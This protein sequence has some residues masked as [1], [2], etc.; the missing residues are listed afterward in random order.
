MVYE[1]KCAQC[2]RV[3][4][5]GGEKPGEG[6]FDRRDPLPENAMEFNG[7]IYCKECVKEFVEFGTG[8]IIER[9]ER[10]E[11][12]VNEMRIELGFEKTLGEEDL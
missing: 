11:E 12:A 1:I 9:I 3:I 5:F 4:D 7:D 8:E 10:L 6:D 2:D